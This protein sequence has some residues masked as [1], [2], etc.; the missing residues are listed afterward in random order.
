MSSVENENLLK[1][2]SEI[3]EPLKTESDRGCVLVVSSLVENVL[4]DHISARLVPKIDKDDE[5][6]G[7]S[8]NSPISNFSAKINLAY[9]IGIITVNERKIYHQLRL[10]RNSCAHQIDQQNFEKNHFKDRIK[11][12]IEESKFLWEIMKTKIAPALLQNNQP[13]SVEE[14]VEAIGWRICFE[15][16]FSLVVAHK[17]TTISRVTKIQPLYVFVAK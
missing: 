16:F 9:R 3:F 2:F 6:M 1:S 15:M 8:I 5:L 4:E 12:I 17:R 7:R 13:K 10:L 11:N 14:F